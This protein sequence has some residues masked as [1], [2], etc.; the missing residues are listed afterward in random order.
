[1]REEPAALTVSAV[2]LLLSIPVPTIR[3]WERRYGV[4][5]PGRTAG[6]HRRYGYREIDELRALRDA[7]ASGLPAA[8][9]AETIRTRNRGDAGRDRVAVIVDAG[10]AFDAQTIRAELERSALELGLDDAIEMV[11]VPVLRHIGTLWQ[12][13]QCDVAHEHLSSQEIRMWLSSRLGTFTRGIP[14]GSALLAC[15]PL[16]L[17]TIGLEAFYVMLVRR[18]LAVRMLG[19]QTPVASLIAAVGSTRPEAVV[20]TSHLSVN[21]RATVDALRELARLPGAVFYAGNAFN[22]AKARRGVP[23]RYLGRRLVPAADVVHGSVIA[24]SEA[25]PA[26]RAR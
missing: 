5:K 13:G 9:A 17:H 6:S 21:R 1:M 26:R 8:E 16:D 14:V 19:A 23:G 20:V 2:S 10:L 22:T 7:I 15:G 18:G 24:T 4:P 3:S 12:A 25:Q 11:V